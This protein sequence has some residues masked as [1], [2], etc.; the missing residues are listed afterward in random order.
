MLDSLPVDR[1]GQ[2][3]GF[4]AFRFGRQGCSPKLPSRR[5]TGAP[6]DVQRDAGEKGS[7]STVSTEAGKSGEELDE[8]RLGPIIEIVSSAEYL[9]QD[10]FDSGSFESNEFG[11]VWRGGT[12][13]QS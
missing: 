9:F 7:K 6:G 12:R 2:R 5:P 4:V 8:Y 10:S 3:A 1:M 13:R 11:D